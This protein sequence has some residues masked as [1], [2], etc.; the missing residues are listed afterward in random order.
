MKQY[1]FLGVF[2]CAVFGLSGTA[3][4]Y[5]VTDTNAYQLTDTTYLF[6]IEYEYGYLNAEAWLSVLARRGSSSAVTAP[7]MFYELYDSA[8]VSVSG[9]SAGFILSDASVIAGR[10]HVPTAERDR[11]TLYVLYQSEQPFTDEVTLQVTQFEHL[12]H[13]TDNTELIMQPTAE[14]LAAYTSSN[15]Q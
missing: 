3:A 10:Y 1:I 9:E 5:D 8:G 15:N 6:A 2:A 13:K 4:A 12:V 7:N 14:Q 11:F